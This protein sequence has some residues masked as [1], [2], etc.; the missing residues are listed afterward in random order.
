MTRSHLLYDNLTRF[1]SHEKGI[2][3]VEFALTLPIMLFVFVGITQVGQAVSISHRVTITARTITDLVTREA[4]STGL[5]PASTIQTD[6]AAAAQVIAPYQSTTLTVTVSQIVTDS[7]G[8]A[9]VDWSQSWPNNNTALVAGSPFTLPSA[10]QGNNISVIYGKV[11]YAYTPILGYKIIQ[12]MTLSDSLY[13]YPR[14]GTCIPV[15]E[16]CPPPQ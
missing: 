13:L 1:I 14:T 4:V 8:N 11:S 16:A 9:K 10:L 7:N 3:A 15:S 12:P 5:V 6:L 2:A